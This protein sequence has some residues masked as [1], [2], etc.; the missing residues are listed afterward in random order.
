MRQKLSQGTPSSVPS[1]M[2]E[3]PSDTL[4]PISCS[5]TC[6][7]ICKPIRH[8][9]NTTHRTLPPTWEEAEQVGGACNY[10]CIISLHLSIQ[11]LCTKGNIADRMLLSRNSSQQSRYEYT[12]C[13]HGVVP[14]SDPIFDYVSPKYTVVWDLSRITHCPSSQGQVSQLCSG[15]GVH[16]YLLF[17]T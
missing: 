1:T 13:Q 11:V 2:S 12:T 3:F 5:Q 14:L 15:F 8:Y 16:M 6:R 7:P 4:F 17:V 9:W 10:P